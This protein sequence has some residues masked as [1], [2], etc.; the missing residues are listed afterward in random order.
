M[1]T[2]QDIAKKAGVTKSTVS[3]YLN[4][5]SISVETAQKIEKVIKEENY[6]PSPFARSLKAKFSSM[7]GVIVPRV[8]SSATA[9]TLMG[10]DEVV[11]ELNYEFIM[12]NSRQ[13]SKREIKAIETFARNKVA[14][15]IL[16]ATEIT[17]NHIKAI[18]KCPVPVVI[19]GQEHHEIHSVIHDDYQAGF[20]LVENLA[21]IGYH[22]ITYVGVSKQDHAVGVVR[23]EGVFSGAKVHKFDKIEQLEGDFSTQKALQIGMD[24][25]KDETHSLV[26][27]A[28]DNIAVAL[29]KAAQQCGRKIP[30]EVAIAGFGGYEIGQFMNPTL[31]TVEYQFKEAGKV[32]MKVLEKL[33][34]NIPCEMKTTI[35][36]HVKLGESTKK[37]E[38]RKMPNF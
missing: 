2:I 11:E 37:L 25:F 32:S 26:I 36:V 21:E 3:R 1:A 9:L 10:I 33:I 6:T 4:G 14:G 13:D 19:V 18:K 31:T 7:I 29:M 27:A 38:I 28:T 15:I 17:S 35:P 5:G 34:R 12:N 8:D 22:E 24:L 16:I 30:E 23:K 20:E